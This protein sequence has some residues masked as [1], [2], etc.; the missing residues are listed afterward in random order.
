M[1]ARALQRLSA[2]V[3]DVV[4]EDGTYFRALTAG[5]RTA[6]ICVRQTAAPSLEVEI[7]GSGGSQLLASVARMLGTDVDLR[8]WERRVKAIPWLE[9]LSRANR[10][11]RP[12]RYPT[13]WEALAHAI[14]FQQIS[15]HAAAAIMRRVVVRFSFPRSHRGI[16]LY[17]FPVPEAIAGAPDAALHAVGLSANK[18]KALK[19]AATAVL[20]ATI[21][22][23][24]LERLESAD[25][26]AELSRLRGIGP[27]SAAVVLLRGLGRLDVFPLKDSGAAAS[28]QLLAERAT[29]DLDALLLELGD[30]RGM[31]YFHLLLGRLA[32]EGGKR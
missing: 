23:Q 25:A 30:Q 3:V 8:S 21:S 12:P 24:R 26:I 32:R 6:I 29:V 28:L 22:E 17:P 5:A 18:A 27:W 11:L 10:G 1:T 2:N 7:F 20:D 9:R 31:L 16:E 13:L 4:T 15:I 19:Q 14:V